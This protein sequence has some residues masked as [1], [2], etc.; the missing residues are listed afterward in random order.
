MKKYVIFALAAVF[1]QACSFT[2]TPT[3]TQIPTKIPAATPVGYGVEFPFELDP[4]KEWGANV[5]AAPCQDVTFVLDPNMARNL[6]AAGGKLDIS[7]GGDSNLVYLWTGNVPLELFAEPEDDG[8]GFG[9]YYDISGTSYCIAGLD[10]RGYT[11]YVN[12]I[13][14]V[15]PQ[16]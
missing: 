5:T 15:M 3:P 2:A 14:K 12:V 6:V 13:T 16:Q 11:A 1:V 10:E 7:E 9:I 4:I 8:S